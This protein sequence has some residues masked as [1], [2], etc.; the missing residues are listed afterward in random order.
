LGEREFQ[1]L[2]SALRG[3]DLSDILASIDASR[4][5]GSKEHLIQLLQQSRF[6]E[7]SLL[8][9]LDNRQIEALLRRFDLRTAGNKSERVD[10]LISR[11]WSDPADASQA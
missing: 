4:V 6:S 11:P 2:F 8:R 9:N 7:E 10:R 5:T 3:Q 1:N